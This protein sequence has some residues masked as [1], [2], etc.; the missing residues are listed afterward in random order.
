MSAAEEMDI[1]IRPVAAADAAAVTRIYNYYIAETCV[2]FETDP[3]SGQEMAR[4]I[5]EVV[6]AALPWLVAEGPDGIAGYAYA[7]RWH[8]RC[9]YRFS[10]ESTVYLDVN[11]TGR[12]VGKQLYTALMDAIRAMSMHAVIGGIALPNEQS[13]RLHERLGF[14][15]VAH[16]EQVAFKQE[17]WIDVGYWQLLF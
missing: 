8:G 6:G 10:V 11:C 4:R 13:I 5:S 14:R 15:K 2:T 9:G 3:V 12:G 1:S 16:F 17:R 7:S